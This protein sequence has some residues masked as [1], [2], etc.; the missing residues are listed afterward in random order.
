MSSASK[1]L[2]DAAEDNNYHDSVMVNSL[3]SLSLISCNAKESLW[4]PLSRHHEMYMLQAEVDGAQRLLDSLNLQIHKQ[5]STLLQPRRE[6][7]RQDGLLYSLQMQLEHKQDRA[8]Q[9]AEAASS[10]RL[11]LEHEQRE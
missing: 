4:L 8:R 5:E 1:T 11:Q 10:A 2:D 7:G 3:V 9:R 6:Q